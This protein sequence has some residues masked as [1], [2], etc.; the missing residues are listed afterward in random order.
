ME[1]INFH[2]SL[3]DYLSIQQELKRNNS[4]SYDLVIQSQYISF[5]PDWVEQEYPALA[6]E[7][8]DILYNVS[9]RLKNQIRNHDFNGAKFK[10]KKYYF[11]F[12]RHECQISLPNEENKSKNLGLTKKEFND[13]L[14]RLIDGDETLIEKIY[15]KQCKT[16][17]TN[18]I[19]AYTC[20][21]EEAYESTIDALYELRKDLIRNKVMYGNLVSY[22]NRRAALVLFKKKRKT[23]IDTISLD[24][25]MD[26]S[27][28]VESDMVDEDV[29]EI[30]KNAISKL[31]TECRQ[32]IRQFY[33][34][35]IKLEEIATELN[36]NHA[37]VRKQ[38]SRCRDKLRNYMGQDFYVKF[39]SSH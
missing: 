30:I 12:L 4:K 20:T 25:D 1:D 29:K 26:F 5:L 9:R 19:R 14:S 3:E 13:M 21:H 36:K 33:F 23:K 10:L 37:T 17:M 6:K 7:A 24:F 22:F 16:C 39:L 15:L 8:N 18:L 27:E 35:E 34:N 31:G 38:I 11:D 2:V 28:E 32:I